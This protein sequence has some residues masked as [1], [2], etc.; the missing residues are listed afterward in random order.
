MKNGRQRIRKISLLI[1]ILLFSIIIYYMPPYLIIR[2]ATEGIVTG[3][4][5]VSITSHIM[6]YH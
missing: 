4:F 2:G 5:V 1:M 6:F 3:R